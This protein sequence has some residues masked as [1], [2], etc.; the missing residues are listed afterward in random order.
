ML[1][2]E[3]SETPVASTTFGDLLRRHRLAAGLTQDLLAAHAGLSA[4]GI[5]KLEHGTTRPNRAT[6]QRLVLALELSHDDQI[7]FRVAGRPAPRDRQVTSRLAASPELSYRHN[8]PTAL[9]SFIGRERELSE[10]QRRLGEARLL[11]LTGVGGCG[12]TRLA[13]ELSRAVLDHY[14][15]G[16]WLVDLGPLVDATLVPQTVAAVLNMR[17]TPGQPIAGALVTALRERSLLLVLDN[18]EH[19]L[20]TCAQLVDALL[21]ACPGLRVLATS[22]EALRLTGE[23]AWRVPS[24]PVPDPHQLHPLAEIQQNAAIRLFVERAVAVQPDFVLTERN[25]SAVIQVC[26]RLDGIPLALELA[27]AWIEALTVDQLT[28][29]LDQRF[30]LLTGGSRAALPRQQTLRAAVDWSYDLLSE[31]ER[32]LFDRL[33][34]FA[35]GWTLEAAEAA[36]AFGV[37]EREGVL[38]LLLRLVRKSL[39]VA[40]ESHGDARRYRLL[41]T[42]RQYAH[43][44]LNAAGETETVRGRHASYYLTLAEE[45]S[46]HGLT[47]RTWLDRLLTEHDNLRAALRWCI[48]CT[49]VEQAV[50]LGGV[51]WPMWVYGGYIT[52]GRAYLRTLLTL[53]GA[54]GVSPTWAQ[55]NWSG[56][57]VEHFAGN[58][59]EARA[60]LEQA[61]AVRRTLGD[62]LGLAS[63]LS[64]LGQVAREQDDY[65]AARAWLEES[66]AIS[67]EA[68]DQRMSAQTLDR[69]GTIAQALGDYRLARSRYEESLALAQQVGDRLEQAWSLHNLGCLALDQGD[70]AAARSWFTQSL[71][72]REEHDS[73]GFVHAL[74]E[75]AALA[76]ADGLPACAARLEG[77]TAALTQKTGILVQHSE[78][79]RYERWLAIARQAVG[80]DVAAAAWVEGQA[81]RL[82]QAI[83]HALAPRE[84]LAA[85]ASTATQPRPTQPRGELTAREREVA[86]LVARGSSNRQIGEALVITERTVAAHIEHTL[87][88]LGFVSRTQ[89]GVW[90]VVHGLVASGTA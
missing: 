32:R 69:V 38:D 10:V 14:P 8:L 45:V 35:G 64:Y 82:D 67:Q 39:V 24:L 88:K 47:V 71:G 50:R 85:T 89:I 11:T 60:R 57:F 59:A 12:K 73:A 17:E 76:A 75:F 68:S 21:H 61:V 16:V 6:V 34:V 56:G 53:P 62:R 23:I 19:V 37:I 36:C 18:C 22:R 74:A 30:R 51:L 20:D 78:R 25:A 41:E 77:A 26:Q 49:A 54:S 81:M 52:E 3:P 33:S 72:L 4:D 2:A 9:T 83:A 43:E 63:A 29:R 46:G 90:A 7:L 28:A 5:R 66:L 42:L 48:E 40:E 70:Y 79:G 84:L 13:L 15:D 1:R 44:S 31:P 55:L 80:E 27:A 65:L 58:Y 87:N 86:V